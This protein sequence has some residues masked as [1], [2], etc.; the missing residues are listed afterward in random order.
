VLIADRTADADDVARPRRRE[1]RLACPTGCVP[2]PM[3][4]ARLAD[5]MA[6]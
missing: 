5:P 1:V 4:L 6:C 3:H 2:P